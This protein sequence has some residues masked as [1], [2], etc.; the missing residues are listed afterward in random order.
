MKREDF[1]RRYDKMKSSYDNKDYKSAQRQG[2][3]IFGDLIKDGINGIGNIF[4][5]RRE[6]KERERERLERE[7]IEREKAERRRKILKTITIIIIIGGI[8]TGGFFLVKNIFFGNNN[9]TVENI[10]DVETPIIENETEIEIKPETP[11]ITVT[12]RNEIE[13]EIEPEK[14]EKDLEKSEGF[15]K[16]IF[17]KTGGFIIDFTGIILDK[18]VDL[19]QS[20]VVFSAIGYG[21]LTLWLIVAVVFILMFLVKSIIALFGGISWGK[22]VHSLLSSVILFVSDVALYNG[23][24][25][26]LEKPITGTLLDKALGIVSFALFL[27]ANVIMI[28]IIRAK[29][30]NANWGTVIKMII[31][32]VIIYI[33]VILLRGV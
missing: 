24:N 11:E 10:T 25:G 8:G 32:G 12:E 23:F 29:N 20:N 21:L 9:T 28:N 1:S 31:V 26:V 4:K 2:N 13:P 16:G 5:N 14:E 7:R 33:P 18:V 22:A 15:F 17:N 27:F 19:P 6:A 30:N 3:S